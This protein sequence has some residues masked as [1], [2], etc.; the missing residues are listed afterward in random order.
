MDLEKSDVTSCFRE[1]I[2]FRVN[3]SIKF[4]RMCIISPNKTLK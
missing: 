2:H 4:R 1:D 3:I